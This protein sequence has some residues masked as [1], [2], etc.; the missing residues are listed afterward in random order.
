MRARALL[1][2]TRIARRGLLRLR[3]RDVYPFLHAMT[4]NDVNNAPPNELQYAA[5]LS[6]KGRVLYDAMIHRVNAE[7]ALLEMDANKIPGAILHLSD[8]RMRKK[9]EFEDLSS[10]LSV[11]VAQLPKV[12]STGRDGE[13]LLDPRPPLTEAELKRWIVSKDAAMTTCPA[14]GDLQYSSLL[15]SLG[16]CEGSEAFEENKSL[17]FDGNLDLLDGVSFEKGCYV[18]QE[19][20]HRT[21]VILVT[22]KRLMPITT[23]CGQILEAASVIQQPLIAFDGSSAGRI[24]AWQGDTGVGLVRLAHVGATA[25]EIVTLRLG[26][27]TDAPM[28]QAVV[29]DWWPI[30][31][32][33]DRLTASTTASDGSE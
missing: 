24:T 22:R 9:V 29:P 32:V 33:F 3:G 16:V 17:P 12:P 11:M 28:V 15:Y 25:G 23:I 30:D 26:K 14:A 19:L 31:Y 21:H 8:Y 1:P 18:G 10:Q 6:S 27:A 2:A 20:T 5:F 7:E 4:T 13:P